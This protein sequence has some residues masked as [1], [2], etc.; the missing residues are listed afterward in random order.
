MIGGFIAGPMDGGGS[1]KV[2]VRAIGPSL[3]LDG[4]LADPFLELHNSNG[5]L[6]GSNDNWRDTQASD[7]Q[8]TGIPPKKDLESALLQT[9]A[10]GNYTA[11]VRGKD[12]TTGIGLIEVYNLP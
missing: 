10:P 3:P 12:N 7:I 6:I 1:A 4:A 5:M 8:A 11:V 9:L 2:L